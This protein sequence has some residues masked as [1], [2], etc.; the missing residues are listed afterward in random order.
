MLVAELEDGACITDALTAT[1][2]SI[3]RLTAAALIRGLWRLLKPL[4]K[5]TLMIFLRAA[6]TAAVATLG[7][8]T[9]APAQPVEMNMMTG[10]P[11]G[12]YFRFGQDISDLGASCGLSIGVRQSAGSVENVFA[13][14]D[15][16]VTQFGIV[17][18]D[19][20]EIFGPTR[21]RIRHF[22]GPLRVCGLPFRSTT[23][24]CISSPAARSPIWAR[25]PDSG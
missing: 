12:T 1:I 5:G 24:R 11:Q 7:I 25:F 23:R 15:R 13:V 14:R 17:Q 22:A 19:V 20:L 21:T 10:G 6:L 8:P 4:G 18:S 16:P 2:G 3:N 9:V